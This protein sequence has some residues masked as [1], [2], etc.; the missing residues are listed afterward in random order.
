MV[1]SGSSHVTSYGPADGKKL[2]EINGPTE[3][4]VASFV[5]HDGLL[6]M[7]GG[8]PERHVLAIRPD[9]SGDVTKTHI[10]WR[11]TKGAG[12]VPS[13][14]ATNHHVFLFNDDGIATC[15]DAKTGKQCWQ[16]RLGRRQSASPITA[17]G[18]IYV[19]EDK[20]TTYVL[21]AGPKYEV[22]AKN[23]FGEDCFASPAV[24][25]GNLF[26]RTTQHLW[27]IGR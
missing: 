3:Q 25:G 23:N 24:S 17:E 1:L 9:G 7:T 8:F 2:W 4:F 6:F 10:A 11:T 14:I 21:T 5:Y 22:L 27:C 20:G 16:E 13:P 19:T 26:Y 12:Y 15:W 18:Q